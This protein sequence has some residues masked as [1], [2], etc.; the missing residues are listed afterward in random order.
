MEEAVRGVFESIQDKYDFLDSMISFGLDQSWRRKMIRLMSLQQGMDI[1][2]CG[3]GTGKLTMLVKKSCESCSITSLDITEK[4]FR[5]SLLSETRFIVG[6]AERLPFEDSSM[7]RVVSAF[8]TRNL[9]SQENYFR[10]SFRVLRKGGLFIN[11]DIYRPSIPVYRE[12]FSLYF[13]HIVPFVGDRIT[14]SKSYSYLAGSVIRFKTVDEIS[15]LLSV[16]GFRVEK[17]LRLM[18]GTVV[19]HVARK[20]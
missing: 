1:L 14:R 5:K 12:L 6:S 13:Y 7:D 20:I 16:S 11:M 8:L 4:M 10:E 9:S 18:M 17:V 2:D 19:I 15:S 3:A